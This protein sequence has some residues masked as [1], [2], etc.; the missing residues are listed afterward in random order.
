[1]K[2]VI[3]SLVF[4]LGMITVGNAKND[5]LTKDIVVVEFSKTIADNINNMDVIETTATNVKSVSLKCWAFKVWIKR[6]LR[7]VSDDDE[8]INETADTLKELCELAK[9]FGLL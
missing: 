9:D 7:K 2:K 4:V 6:E 1:M 8:L 3:L 5:L